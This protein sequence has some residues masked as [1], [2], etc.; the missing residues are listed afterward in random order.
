MA[1]TNHTVYIK[2]N[3]NTRLVVTITNTDT[4]GSLKEKMSSDHLNCFPVLGEINVSAIKVKF[5]KHFYN[6]SD[7]ILVKTVFERVKGTWFLYVDALE[8]E[9]NDLIRTSSKTKQSS[10]KDDQEPPKE[11]NGVISRDLSNNSANEKQGCTPL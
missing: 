11:H 5:N 2:T 7:S 3:L 6:L 1:T 4:A 8:K 9:Q 10:S